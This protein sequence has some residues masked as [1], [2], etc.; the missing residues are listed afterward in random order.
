MSTAAADPLA[1]RPFGNTGLSVPPIAVGTAPMGDMPAAFGYGVPEDE[2]VAT[3]HAALDSPI[4]YVD[5][6]A[7]YGDGESERRVGLAR[8][9]CAVLLLRERIGELLRIDQHDQTLESAPGP[10]LVARKQ[11]VGQAVGCGG[12]CGDRRRFLLRQ[13]AAMVEVRERQLA[14]C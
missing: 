14:I 3:I 13:Q 9:P 10:P 4:P 6:A 12:R 11:P 1:R 7:L 5:T 2:A 8:D